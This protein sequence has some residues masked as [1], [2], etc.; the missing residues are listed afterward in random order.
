MK[1]N[2]NLWIDIQ[3]VSPEEKEKKKRRIGSSCLWLDA[4][5]A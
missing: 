5:Q 2:A 4:A 3:D 1:G